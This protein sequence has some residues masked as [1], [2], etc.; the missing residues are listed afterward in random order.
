MKKSFTMIELIF[1]IVIIGILASVALPKLWAT[2]DDAVITKVRSDVANIRSAIENLHT[3]KLMM[4]IDEYP[5][6]LDDAKK[7]TEGEKLFDGNS[8]IGQLLTYPIYSKNVDGHWMKT[9]DE[10]SNTDPITKYSV[11]IMNN[12]IEFDYNNSNGHFDCDGL[13][14]GEANITCAKLTH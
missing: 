7:N 6:A 12:D 3:Q 10:Y 5:E 9:D 1:V 4:G 8:S 13:N 14:S 2:R 11:K